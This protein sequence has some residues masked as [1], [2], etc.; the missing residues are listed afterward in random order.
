MQKMYNCVKL[1]QNDWCFQ[2]YL[3][4]DDLNENNPVEEKIIKT[5]IYGVKCSGNQAEC[6]LRK[7]AIASEKEFPDVHRIIMKDLYVDDCI[8]GENSIEEAKQRSDELEMVL[9]KGGFSLK[10]ITMS[11]NHPS[12]ELSINGTTISIAGMSWQPKDDVVS[13][14]VKQVNF[15]KKCRGRKKDEIYKVPENLT[16]RHCT[17][18][19]AEIFDLTGML[20]PIVATMKLDLHDLVLLKLDWDDKIPEN[21][22]QVW[23]NHFEMMSEINTLKYERAIVP[24]DAVDTKIE[25]FGFGDASKVMIC[26]AIYVRFLKRNGEYSCQL[27]FGRSKLVPENMTLP[28]AELF[29]ALTNCHTGEVVNRALYQFH[30]SDTK[31]SDSQIVLHWLSNDHRTLKQWV[32][33]RVIEIQRLTKTTDWRY[34]TSNHMVADLGTRR[35][36]SL[37]D[38]DSTS[39]WNKGMEWMKLPIEEI[40]AFTIADVQFNRTS[41]NSMMRKKKDISTTLTQLTC[42]KAFQTM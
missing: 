5:I 32:R 17:A 35:G 15:A 3:W 25:T 7:T 22:R 12:K 41:H 27:V 34:I 2:R 37:K 39:C 13:L 9:A 33:N 26:V 40:P 30:K 16:R 18:K 24:I 23:L 1:D 11:G 8:S 28:R 19:V 42:T 14:D 6:G 20:T 36:A 10:G 29:A 38:V 4:K 21:L 31:F